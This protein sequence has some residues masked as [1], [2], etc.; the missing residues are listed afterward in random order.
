VNLVRRAFE[1]QAPELIK[2]I[3]TGEDNQKYTGMQFLTRVDDSDYT[4]MRAM[5][6]TIGYPEYSE[7]VEAK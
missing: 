5:Y 1:T 6:T 7:F 2:A 4:D 3:L